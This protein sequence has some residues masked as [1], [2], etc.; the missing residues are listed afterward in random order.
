MATDT[1]RE[2]SKNSQLFFAFVWLIT[3]TFLL[4][5]FQTVGIPQAFGD[6]RTA[7]VDTGADDYALG[8]P[9]PPDHDLASVV[10]AGVRWSIVTTRATPSEGLLSPAVIDVDVLVENTLAGTTARI[11]ERSVVLEARSG[12]VLGTGRFVDE[13]NRL[14]IAPGETLPLTISF[15]TGSIDPRASDLVLRIGDAGRTPSIL[16]LLGEPSA[17]EPSFVA[18]DES[19]VVLADPDAADRQIVVAPEAAALTLNAGPYRAAAGEQLALVTV[20]VERAVASDDSTFLDTS[21]WGFSTDEGAVP[22]IMVARAAQPASNADQV[23][24]LFAFPETADD[25]DLVVGAGTSDE[26][27]VS[28]VVP[29]G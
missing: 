5:V 1:R 17:E 28:I 3:T 24:L 6:E 14:S 20:M 10:H 23:T 8:G 4:V 9:E 12:E 25:F 16:P 22:A 11:P 26:T 29:N 7:L 21:Y 27:L 13:T 2:G 19:I 18:I 15:V